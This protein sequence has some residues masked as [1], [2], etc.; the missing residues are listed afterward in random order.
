MLCDS[1]RR[2]RNTTEGVGWVKG[3]SLEQKNLRLGILDTKGFWCAFLSRASD[4]HIRTPVL[5]LNVQMLYI[6]FIY[7]SKVSGRACKKFYRFLFSWLKKTLCFSWH[8]TM[9]PFLILLRMWR[10]FLVFLSLCGRHPLFSSERKWLKS[11]LSSGFRVISPTMHRA[12]PAPLSSIQPLTLPRQRH[13]TQS[14]VLQ[15]STQ[16]SEST[17]FNWLIRL[18]VKAHTGENMVK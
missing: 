8:H 4:T 17:K 12:P 6:A 11:A 13:F 2:G 5:S 7:N 15:Q 9:C 14:G 16:T 18:F 10:W 1:R 3:R